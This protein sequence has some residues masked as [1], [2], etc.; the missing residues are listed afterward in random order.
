MNDA[1]LKDNRPTA[2]AWHESGHTIACHVL[3]APFSHVYGWPPREIDGCG[4]VQGI[5]L[6]LPCTGRSL[7][8]ALEIAM[9]VALA[10]Q[11]AERRP[12]PRTWLANGFEG[13][14]AADNIEFFSAA[15]AYLTLVRESASDTPIARPQQQQRATPEAVA[16]CGGIDQ[17]VA[18][19]IARWTNSPAL[20]PK[21]VIALRA[22]MLRET[23]QLLCENA[24]A[25]ERV[26]GAL[27]ESG[28]RGLT[29]AQVS[30]L[31]STTA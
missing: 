20:I 18:D 10:G 15:Y 7:K 13:A 6:R 23:E 30:A 16:A 31:I 1:L 24:L 11:I 8:D 29:A 12:C 5:V 27:L 25:V 21:E 19:T 28:H 17:I 26:A 9:R 3:G 22:R 4:W 2:I 14:W